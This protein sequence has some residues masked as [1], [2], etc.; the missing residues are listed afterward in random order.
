MK[1]LTV[2]TE[3]RACGKE[4]PLRA[5][6]CPHCGNIPVTSLIAAGVVG[7]FLLAIIGT[8]LTE[9]EPPVPEMTPAQK[10]EE[11]DLHLTGEACSRARRAVLNRLKAP[12]S[13]DF[14][15]CIFGINKYRIRADEKRETWLVEGYVDAQNS[16]GAMLRN[17]WIVKLKRTPG[18][19][20]DDSWV[21][22]SIAVGS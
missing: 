10:R 21:V 2:K 16:Y 7:L 22:L 13:A 15:S 18:T 17:R 1:L 20:G 9:K 3:C 19:K 6:T 14:P 5:L 12:K 8:A 11:E 4:I